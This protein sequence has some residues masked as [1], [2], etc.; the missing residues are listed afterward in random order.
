MLLEKE[1]EMHVWLHTRKQ[2]PFLI[3]VVLALLLACPERRLPKKKNP[4][5]KVLVYSWS[6]ATQSDIAITDLTSF[7]RLEGYHFETDLLIEW[8][9]VVILVIQHMQSLLPITVAS[10]VIRVP[11]QQIPK[12]CVSNYATL[13]DLKMRTPFQ[14]SVYSGKLQL[15]N[16]LPLV[17]LLKN[18]G[19]TCLT[20]EK[21]SF[22]VM[23]SEAQPGGKGSHEL[24]LTSYPCHGCA[25][26]N[27][28]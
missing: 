7:K 20:S 19:H 21:I 26:F 3:V 4:N 22:T 24:S 27:R 8:Q 13:I 10:T 15:R 1:R 28:N 12:K 17:S 23:L 18:N 2:P 5:Q 25:H 11:L 6:I 14:N 9:S 16:L